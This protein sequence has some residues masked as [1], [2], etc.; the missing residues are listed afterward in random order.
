MYTWYLLPASHSFQA[1]KFTK[2]FLL[3]SKHVLL[4]KAI[5][6]LRISRHSCSK[7]WHTLTKYSRVASI[8]N[9]LLFAIGSLSVLLAM[10]RSLDERDADGPTGY[11]NYMK[12][13]NDCFIP[14]GSA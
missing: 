12:L 11:A 5:E 13:F 9:I 7:I 3:I 8:P 2:F 4:K 10:I 6:E 14:K 1:S